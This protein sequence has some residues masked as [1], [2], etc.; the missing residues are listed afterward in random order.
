[1]ATLTATASGGTRAWSSTATW[2]P[3]QV[4]TAADN[5]VLNATSGAVTI[6]A[7]ALGR[8]LDCTGY[9]NTLTHTAGVTLTLGDATSGAGNI[10]LK[11]VAGMTYT[12]GS[13]STSEIDFVSTSATQQTIDAGGKQI[14]VTRFLGAGSSYLL[15]TSY[16]QTGAATFN[17]QQGTV[18]T[19][20]LAHTLGSFSATTAGAKTFTMGSSAI[21]MVGNSIVNIFN[22]MTT[23]TFTANTAVLTFNATAATG[24]SA[25][26]T[27]NLNGASVV[28]PATALNAN[29]SGLLTLNNVTFSGVSSKTATLTFSGNP[30]ITGTL[31]VSGS[32]ATNRPLV[33]SSVIGTARTVTTAAF[34]FSNVDFSDMTSAGAGGTWTGTSMGDALGNTGITTNAPATQTHTSSAGGNWSDSTKWTSRVPLPQDNVVVDVNTTGTLTADM[35]RMGADITFAGFAGTLATTAALSLY[36]SLTMASGMTI[37]GS[38]GWTARG[39]SSLT[40]TSA[41]KTFAGLLTIDAPGGTYT[42][43]DNLTTGASSASSFNL[44]HGGFV[45]NGKTVST[46]NVDLNN[47]N[48]GRSL[49]MTGT[50]QIN[51]T[52][53]TALWVCQ[54]SGLTLTATGSVIQVMATSTSTRAFAGGGLT[55]GTLTHTLAGSTGAMSITGS[56]T[57]NTLNFSD[58]TNARSLLFTAATTTTVT[59]FN[60]FGTATKLMTISSVTAATHTLSNPSPGGFVSD[61]LS[62]DHSIATGGSGWFAGTHSTDGGSNTGWTFAFPTSSTPLL[63]SNGA[64]ANAGTPAIPGSASLSSNAAL[65]NAGTPSIPGATSLSSNGALT[66]AGIPSIPGAVSLASNGALTSAGAPSIPGAESLSS[67]GALVASGTP[68]PTGALGL[69]GY[70]ALTGTGTPSVSGSVALSGDG[71]LTGTGTPSIPGAT[72]LSSDGALTNTGI[73]SIPGAT[74][75]SSD[76]A[77]ATSGIP[78]PTGSALLSSNGML[79]ANGSPSP[80]GATSLSSNG[81]LSATGTSMQANSINLI[82]YGTFSAVGTPSIPGATSLSSDGALST[83]GAPGLSGS[84]GLSSD[85]A[86]LASGVPTPFGLVALSADSILSGVG[87]PSIASIV[88]LSGD[89]A[90]MASGTPSIPGATFLFANGALAFFPIITVVVGYPVGAPIAAS[91]PVG[92]SVA[93]GDPT[94]SK[95]VVG[96]PRS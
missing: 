34:S 33:Q 54:S 96:T 53:A 15:S 94:G 90:L 10:A 14:G 82:A 61:Y 63:G 44:Q 26:V 77:L 7:G 28:F 78:S 13:T 66:N 58:A 51:A 57:F 38:Q 40:I 89:S 27:T 43:Q 62:I 22:V 11:F 32:N 86:L 83:S 88:D 55:Y 36:G 30:T 91:I 80:T 87:T 79:T 6:D 47:V 60:V 49:T 48:T 64:L 12:Q 81:T 72:S 85:G 95:L 70:G 29:I 69:L 59:N 71:A 68:S 5:C 35:P 37:T 4:P 19:N 92:A 31:T 65:T 24:I 3:A 75:L 76:G 73:P 67:N 20:N 42:L 23:T 16:L 74:S 2:S 41:G 46:F 25:A 50:W 18:N 39:R 1:M 17:I 84:I 21:S 93:V 45:D 8:S 56:N 9:I 52:G